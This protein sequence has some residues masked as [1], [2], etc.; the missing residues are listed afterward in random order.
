VEVWKLDPSFYTKTHNF[1]E[2][3]KFRTESMLGTS[4]YDVFGQVRVTQMESL[5]FL[6]IGQL[7]QQT[8]LNSLIQAAD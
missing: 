1:Q 5:M 6:W 3:A 7:F 4:N 2:I 8:E